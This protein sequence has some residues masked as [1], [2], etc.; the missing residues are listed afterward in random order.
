MVNLMVE[1]ATSDLLIGPD[2]ARN[3][4]I[5][6]MLN[7]DPGQA[8]DVVKGIKKRIGSKNSKVQLLALTLLETIVK[9]CGDIVHMHVAEKEIPHE[10]VRIAKRKPDFH[11][12]EKILILIDT[13]QEAFGGPRARY[14]Q[15]YAAYQELL[16]AGAV[17]PQKSE[18]SAPV[19]TP[20]QTQ[21]LSS[22]P[23]NLRNP[24]SRLQTTE[25]SSEPEYP[26][27]SLSEIQNARGIMDVLAEMLSAIDPANKD[28]IRQEVVVDLVEQCRT[29]KQRVVHLVNSTSDESLLCQGLALNDDLQKVLAK[30]EAIASGNSLLLKNSEPESSKGP[31]D[32]DAPLVDT[33]ENSKQTDARSASSATTPAPAANG[34]ETTSTKVD[35]KIDLLSGDLLSGDDFNTPTA[36]DT[37]ALVPVSAPQPTTSPTASQQ[38]ALALFDMFNTNST[39]PDPSHSQHTFHGAQGYPLA[40]EFQR[41]QNQQPAQTTPFA[42]GMGLPPN[43]QMGY[44]Q[45]TG[46]SW[47]AQAGQ[48]QPQSPVYEVQNSGT[49]PPPPWESQP[50]ETNTPFS[51][52]YSPSMQASPMAGQQSPSFQGGMHPFAPQPAGNDQVS[53]MYSQQM[54]GHMP[55]MNPQPMQSHPGMFPQ[56]YTGQMMGTA[57]QAMPHGQTGL[58][59]P[60][61]MYANQ[62]GGYG[63]GYTQQPDTQ[64]LDQRMY[65]MSLRDDTSLRNSSDQTSMAS[66]LPPMR[67]QPKGDDK[68]FGDLVDMAK[69]KPLKS[70]PGGSI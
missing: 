26:T 15:Y 28:A 48:Q 60:T 21:P 30:H 67:Q 22:Y 64:Y 2:W 69:L 8:K 65:G 3:I 11:V 63:Y 12:K 1:R 44:P 5:C 55:A 47:S 20:P 58:M 14:P 32:V 45:P 59:Y 52:Q 16:R 50:T 25:G 56:P 51:P 70:A 27:L 39:T 23:P 4:E 43:E 41:H 53:G 7:H 57:P 33:G 35:P 36:Q 62:M 29:Y 17:F 42:N 46:A 40:P 68:L 10:M 38:N 49:L 66:Y 18:R 6:D 61:Q 13:W 19:F 24:E 31:V 37:L 34:S 54:T 9:N